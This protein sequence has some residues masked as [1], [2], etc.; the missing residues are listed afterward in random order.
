MS[1]KDSW[2]RFRMGDHLTTEELKDLLKEL[3]AGLTYLENRGVDFMLAIRPTKLDGYRIRETLKERG[4]HLS[5]VKNLPGR[6][7][8]PARPYSSAM[9]ENDRVDMDG[10]VY[11]IMVQPGGDDAIVGVRDVDDGCIKTVDSDD[12]AARV[13]QAAFRGMSMEA[14]DAADVARASMRAFLSLRKDL[15]SE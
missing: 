1:L 5:E 2:E 14:T 15:K 9:Q 8:G 13:Y 7:K 12:V 6:S 4:V 3:E 10:K 11:F